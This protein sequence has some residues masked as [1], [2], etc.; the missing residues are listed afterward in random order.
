M[1]GGTWKTQN[2][3]R[4]GA[5]INVVGNGQAAANPSLGRVL[6]LR[7]KGLGWGANGVLELNNGTDWDEL[8][9]S[10]SDPDMIVV[11]EALK[12]ANTVLLMNPNAGKAATLSKANMPWDFTAKYVGSKGN[13]ISVS[14]EAVPNTEDQATINTFFGTRLVDQQSIKLEDIDKFTGNNYIVAKPAATEVTAFSNVQGTLTGG[15]DEKITNLDTA[16]NDALE[17]ENYAVATT[18]GFDTNSNIHQ[19]LTEAIKRLRENEGRKVRGVVPTDGMTSYDYEG[20]SA[21]VNGYVLNSGEVVDVKDAAGLFAGLSAS[22]DAGTSLTYEEVPDAVEAAPKFNNEKTITSLEKGEIVFTSK[23]GSRVVIEQDI[24]SLT[25]FTREKT[26]AFSKNRVMRTIDTIVTDTEDVFE[27]SFLGKVGNNAN[28]RDLFKANRAAYL[29]SLLDKNIIQNFK[30][31]DITVE[32]G[33]D[34]DS[35]LVNL[36]VTPVDAM[37]KLY[38]TMVVR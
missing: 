28:G 3:R 9:V 35:I 12:G 37:E 36:A 29:Q 19:I 26:V 11:R 17:N 2:K 15:T 6:I 1:A 5:Y 34:S 21:V 13:N 24:N 10:L 25:T 16:I 4:P 18:A 23:P 8:G 31:T 33:N 22:A 27:Q 30:N 32:P 38:M 14:V 7:D 20:I